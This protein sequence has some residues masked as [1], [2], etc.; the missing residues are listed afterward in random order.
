MKSGPEVTTPPKS[1]LIIGAGIIGLATALQLQQ[2]GVLVTV[3]D[4]QG[5]GQGASYGNGGILTPAGNI[6]VSTPGLLKNVPRMWLDPNGP[7]FLRLRDMP[8]MARFFQQYRKEC[9]ADR[10][11]A[12]ASALAGI[13]RDTLADH[14]A[15]TMDTKAAAYISET[16]YLYVWHDRAGF[17]A[18]GFSWHLRQE[19][20]FKWDEHEG[21]ALQQ[22]APLLHESLGF[23]VAPHKSGRISDPGAYCQALADI[24]TQRGGR[25]LNA[26]FE[27][28]LRNPQGHVTGVRAGGQIVEADVTIIC[29]GIHSR[30]MMAQLG[31]K[32]PMIAE[33]GYHLELVDTSHKLEA[34]LMIAAGK[35]VATQMDGRIR[36]AGLVEIAAPDA[37]MRQKPLQ[38]LERLARQYLPDLAWRET[39]GWVG[40]RPAPVDSV[41]LI[42][43]VPDAKGAFCA[44]GHHHIGLTSGPKTGE[45]ITRMVCGEKITLDISPYDPARFAN[46]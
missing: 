7:L 27:G 12:A 4:K 30:E 35:F 42:G 32:V 33:R 40:S 46:R 18:D 43:A 20:G 16:P 41:P 29:A 22:L 15:L 45:L 39:R 37:P 19:L 3:I 31:L 23:A 13:T 11:R 24:L 2:R 8:R 14:L 44:F 17:E 10:T 25:F 6:P 34:S 5:A 26:D 36:L 1:A 9:R 38:L 21:A 28:F